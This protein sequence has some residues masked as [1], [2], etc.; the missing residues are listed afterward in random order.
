MIDLKGKGFTIFGL[1][2]SGKSKLAESILASTDS[3]LVYDPHQEHPSVMR[4]Y[5]P[6]DRNSKDELNA[7]I[8]RLVI[9]WKPALFII[10]EANR[11]V[12][13]KPTP[14]PSGVQDLV[15]NARHWNIAFGC[16]ARRPT[17]FNS[18]IVELSDY[19]FLFGLPG[20]NDHKYL[21]DLKRG[22]G[23]TVIS[24]PEYHFVVVDQ[25]RNY[26]VHSPVDITQTYVL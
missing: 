14:M 15:D 5:I 6:K 13:P 4:R 3:H 8:T 17:Q 18:D 25:S 24:L 2:G 9:P 16:I 23:D 12:P 7:V 21:N 10:D 19:I 20:K 26:S 11:Y 1:R 22:L